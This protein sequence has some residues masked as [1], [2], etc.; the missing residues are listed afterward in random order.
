[1]SAT[2]Q[3]PLRREWQ[4]FLLAVGFLTRIPLPPDPDFSPAKL[5]GAGRYF[6]L[7]GALL[8]LAAAAGLL[9]FVEVFANAVVAVLLSM[10]MLLVL[11]GGFHEDGLA[12]TADG[13]GGA[14]QRD[15]VLR[16]MKDSRIGS[17]GALALV[18][19]L[20]LKAASLSAMTLS[21]AAAGLIL[22]QFLSRWLAVSF[23]IDMPYVG[24]QGKSRPLA[25]ALRP[26]HWLLA[27]APLLLVLPLASPLQWLQII[28]A[29][30]VFRLWFARLLSRRLQGYSGDT[31]GAAQ[32]LSELL[33][34]LLLLA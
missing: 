13:F 14:W 5:D 33:V 31:L 7:V 21:Q 27:G 30:V 26:S 3:S 18:M 12:D 19:V 20:L 10:A 32:Q 2:Q 8:G 6:P 17:Y 25:T 22:G 29:L 34:Y 28:A 11:T 9:V 16:I 23:L 4:V 1:M 15:D 24:G